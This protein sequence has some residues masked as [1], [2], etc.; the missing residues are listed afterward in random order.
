MQ[1]LEAR[2][3]VRTESAKLILCYLTTLLISNTREA[4][5]DKLIVMIIV[6]NY[7]EGRNSGL[8]KVSDIS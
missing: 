4:L 2:T 6:E 5:N 8:F 3:S 1:L 7:A